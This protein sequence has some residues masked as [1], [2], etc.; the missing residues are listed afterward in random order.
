MREVFLLLL[1]YIISINIFTNDIIKI[2][3]GPADHQTV[4]ITSSIIKEA[5]NRLNIKIE[6][7]YTS[8]PRSL[9]ITNNGES[10]AELCRKANI[11]KK[12]PNL[13]MVNAPLLNLSLVAFSKKQELDIKTWEDLSNYRIA[14]LRGI[15]RIEEKT[16][17]YNAYPMN[18][19]EDAFKLLAN[20]RVDVVI[21]DHFN[22][23]KTLKH[24]GLEKIY[25]LE[26]PLETTLLYHYLHVK[27]EKLLP[28]L[29]EILI[30]MTEDGTIKSITKKII[31]N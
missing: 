3:T 19:L 16:K 23:L 2:S 11:N 20:N 5:Y 15:Q 28:C 6:F 4:I 21:V 10:D 30:K 24:M 1:L 22:G 9:E 14:F 13:I 7:N 18:K 8:W 31:E 26:N 17:G 12:F 29:E 25:A 27:H